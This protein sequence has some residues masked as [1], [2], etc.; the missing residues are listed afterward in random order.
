M[1]TPAEFLSVSVFSTI[2][3]KTKRQKR[4]KKKWK[5]ATNP[6][7]PPCFVRC[8]ITC[9]YNVYHCVL[10]FAPNPFLAKVGPGGLFGLSSAVATSVG[11]RWYGYRV[12]IGN[13]S[14]INPSR[15]FL[16]DSLPLERCKTFVYDSWDVLIG[17]FS[18]IQQRHSQPLFEYP[19]QSSLSPISEILVAHALSK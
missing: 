19:F 13:I 2:K 5:S 15:F 12:L 11:K 3:T 7:T 1:Y 17:A 18:N 4:Q 8:S 10:S 14:Y 6:C 9:V 16:H